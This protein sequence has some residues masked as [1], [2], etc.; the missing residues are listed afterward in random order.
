MSVI[1]LSSTVI[2]KYGQTLGWLRIITLYKRSSCT[3]G[4]KNTI[5]S[6]GDLIKK[7]NNKKQAWAELCQAHAKFD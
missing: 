1:N 4:R 3:V 6:N 5:C 7:E 2:T